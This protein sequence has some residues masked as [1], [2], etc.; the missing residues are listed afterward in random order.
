MRSR[1]LLAVVPIVAASFAARASEVVPDTARLSL[2]DGAVAGRLLDAP[3]GADGA[4]STLLWQSPHFPAPFEFPLDLV[5]RIRFPLRDDAGQDAAG[6]WTVHLAGGNEV[7]GTLVG[8]DDRHVLVD[9]AGA[10][11]GQRLSI[12]REAVRGIGR[13]GVDGASEWSGDPEAWNLSAPADWA[14][15]EAGLRSR[16]AG[17]R[18][19]RPLPEALKRVRI[20]LDLEV[21]APE[22][23][24]AAPERQQPQRAVVVWPGRRGGR[25]AQGGRASPA[26][27]MVRVTL[28]ETLRPRPTDAEVVNHGQAVEEHAEAPYALLLGR[29]GMVLVRDEKNAVGAGRADLQRAGDIPEGRFALS[30]FVDRDAGRATLVRSADGT[31]LADLTVEPTT[32][33]AVRALAIEVVAGT[34]VINALRVAPWRG[35]EP[36][37]DPHDAGTVTLR[38]GQ[39]RAG[40]VTGLADGLLAIDAA[41]E[42]AGGDQGPIRLES[43]ESIEFPLRA[44][45]AGADSATLRVTDRAGNR[46]AGSLSRVAEGAVW[47]RHPAIDGELRLPLDH[48]ASLASLARA[49]GG[50]GAAAAPA[51]RPGR[52]TID[53]VTMTGCLESTGSGDTADGVGWRPSGS[54][55]ASP[56][57]IGT[58]AVPARIVYESAAKEAGQGEDIGWLGIEV[59][60]LDGATVTSLSPDSPAQGNVQP[61]MRIRAIAPIPG[62]PFVDTAELPADEIAMLLEG[63][64]GTEVRLRLDDPDAHAASGAPRMLAFQRVPRPGDGPRRSLADLA[65]VHERLLAGGAAAQPDPGAMASRLILVS[66][67]SVSCAVASIDERGL[68]IVVDGGAAVTVPAAAVQAVELVP[69]SA[70][71]ISAEK[72]RSLVTV[73]RSQ[74]S[75]P[76]THLVRSP[77][78]DYLRGR[79][80]SLDGESLR[81]AVDA[82]PRG[83]PTVIPR[84]EVARVIW[85]HP[86]MLSDDWQAPAE[87]PATGLVVEGIWPDGTRRRL[88]ARAIEGDALVGTHPLLGPSRIDLGTVERLVIGGG[89]DDAPRARPFGQWML[90]PA[91]DPRREP[92][93]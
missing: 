51:G 71:R 19:W 57:P 67:E 12:A 75:A 32:G 81:I 73:P 4:R 61:R 78:G 48:L 40:K 66:G 24:A 82:Q 37:V 31:I 91:S 62:K 5:E 50:G 54:L 18:A 64:I 85:L 13:V 53:G 68:S 8:I 63:P 70:R 42:G 27:P 88:A 6:A 76:P 14:G 49:D 90:R 15:V 16:R 9:A 43:V 56:L 92:P 55:L 7:I 84:S 59:D 21:R 45:P 79:L 39:S 74:R 47:I 20:D 46:L 77:R 3:P 30:L 80:V 72:F 83:K 69:S 23:P 41:P 22:A 35:G 10:G 11:T 58:A 29:F 65:A 26:A 38:G 36:G 34:V 89:L 33:R 87:D 28:G 86:E 1:V 17:A 2:P 93:R 44:P 52:M 25:G 60:P